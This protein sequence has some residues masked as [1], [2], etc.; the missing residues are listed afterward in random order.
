MVGAGRGGGSEDAGEVGALAHAEDDEARDSR[1]EVERL[2]HQEHVVDAVEPNRGPVGGI[3]DGHGP[4]GRVVLLGVVGVPREVAPPLQLAAELDP[5]ALHGVVPAC[6]ANDLR[7]HERRRRRRLLAVPG[8]EPQP[9]LG[10]EIEGGHDYLRSTIC[11]AIAP[12]PEAAMIETKLHA[13][14]SNTGSSCHTFD[15]R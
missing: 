6:E 2:R 5:G 10:P 11:A 8:A 14:P 9:P 7:R 4:R 12:D 3:R 1:A 13:S 15:G